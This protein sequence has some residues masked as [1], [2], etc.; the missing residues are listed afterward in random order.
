MAKLGNG[1]QNALDLR[2]LDVLGKVVLNQ[3]VQGKKVRDGVSLRAWQLENFISDSSGDSL[4]VSSDQSALVAEND[5]LKKRV[6][7][8]SLVAEE[9]NVRHVDNRYQVRFRIWSIVKGRLDVDW[10]V[11]CRGGLA[12]L[13]ASQGRTVRRR[14]GDDTVGWTVEGK[15]E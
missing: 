1:D 9:E 14:G 3:V 15:G 10:N 6:L 8:G 2:K 11:R 4:T 13:M 5:L 7:L 12:T